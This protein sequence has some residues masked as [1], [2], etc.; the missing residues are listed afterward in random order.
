LFFSLIKT[1]FNLPSCDFPI[2]HTCFIS[3]LG[4]HGVG[5]L[6]HN[7]FLYFHIILHGIH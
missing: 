6:V 7:I 3:H 1:Q 4:H 2:Y 5:S